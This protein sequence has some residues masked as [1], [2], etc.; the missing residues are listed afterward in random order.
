MFL[1]KE[2]WAIHEALGNPAS[3]AIGAWVIVECLFRGAVL[4]IGVFSAEGF[5]TMALRMGTA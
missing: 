4:A 2:I 5:S 3:S 1:C